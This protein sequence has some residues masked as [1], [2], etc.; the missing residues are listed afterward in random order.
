[1]TNS[2]FPTIPE[3]PVR[4]REG[5][6][7]KRGEHIKNW[8]P[9]YFVLLS[10]G[11][12]LG[13]KTAPGDDLAN[14]L[15]D[16]T[17][18]GSQILKTDRPKPFTFIMRALQQDSVT[19]ERMFHVESA[20]ERE[21][22]CSSIQSLADKFIV[23]A[24]C[25]APSMN[26]KSDKLY[27]V[28]D[29][30]TTLKMKLDDFE[31]IKLLGKGTFGKV[32]LGKERSSGKLYA[33]KML[34][35]EVII[36]KD[37][38]EHTLTERRVLQSTRHPFLT[39]LQY[40]FQTRDRL[41][42]V[43]EYVN[44]G[45]LFFHLSRERT[46]DEARVRFYGAEIVLGLGY[47]HENNIIYRDLKLENILLDSD[48]HIKL[49]DFGLC[50]AD[51]RFSDRTKTFCGTPEYLAPEVLDD[52]DYGRAV[53]WWAL[54]VVLYEMLCGRLP[55]HHRSHDVLFDMIV[56]YDVRYP[57][58]LSREARSLLSGLLNKKP[59]KRLGG[60]PGDYKEIQAHKY[61]VEIDWDE[62]YARRVAPPFKPQVSSESTDTRYFEQEFTGRT[63]ELT[64][65]AIPAGSAEAV[66]FRDF[67]YPQ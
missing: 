32:M 51:L 4:I 11:S 41:C 25:V 50:K 46:F 57:K 52:V 10:N 1:M 7:M 65:P 61:F 66:W 63:I 31:Y 39:Y 49:T 2:Q 9:R 16:F 19:I 23:S 42:F 58:T 35:K 40:A 45:E 18:K 29:P 14:P 20:E 54:G 3:A 48:G 21:L 34:R 6:L 15:N 62:L 67:S 13:F 47:L 55:F 8:R 28:R 22:W 44:G 43:M 53:D 56:L 17:V 37:E 60:G 24:D 36:S 26:T 12:L 5:W 30:S 38:V 33:V 64:P 59:A 27:T